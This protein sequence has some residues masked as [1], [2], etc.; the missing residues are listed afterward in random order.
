MAKYP[1][2]S[3]EW[4]T[5]ARRIYAGAG[6]TLDVG[7]SAA[8]VRVNLVVTEVPFSEKPLDAHLDTT[9]GKVAIDTGHLPEADVTVSMDYATART[10]FV[11][12]DVQAVMQAFLAGRVRVDGD[13]SKLLDPRSGIWPGSLAGAAGG[14][15]APQAGPPSGQGAT[16][17]PSPATPSP[18]TPSPATPSPATPSPATPSPVASVSQPPLGFPTPLQ[19][20][21][22]LQEI[23][24]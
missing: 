12:G 9:D 20:A 21:S 5:E 4:V 11:G 2:L 3:D 6:I 16:A 18:V 15:A 7:A 19:L 1:F 22:Q 24:E 13:L 10:L 23:T 14:G 8:P 17:T